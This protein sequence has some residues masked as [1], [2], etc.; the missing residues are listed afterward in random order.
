MNYAILSVVLA[1]INSIF[2]STLQNVSAFLAGIIMDQHLL[3]QNIWC[4]Q[5]VSV[6]NSFLE[7]EQ[8]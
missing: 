1:V 7:K 4:G 6:R 3:V 8:R 2:Y 5:Q